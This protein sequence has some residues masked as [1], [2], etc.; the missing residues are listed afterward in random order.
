MHML[1]PTAPAGR[2][3]GWGWG[4]AW[5]GVAAYLLLLLLLRLA[6]DTTTCPARGGGVRGAVPTAPEGVSVPVWC[7]RC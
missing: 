6:E 5:G 2:V 3:G 7:T 4:G 1:L